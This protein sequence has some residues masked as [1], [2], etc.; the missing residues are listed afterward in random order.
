MLSSAGLRIG[1]CWCGVMATSLREKEGGCEGREKKKYVLF[2]KNVDLTSRKDNP[3]RLLGTPRPF[4]RQG[5]R[6]KGR[7]GPSLA[8]LS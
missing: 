8:A 3:P 5:D 6:S 1:K 2:W 7:G 4:H